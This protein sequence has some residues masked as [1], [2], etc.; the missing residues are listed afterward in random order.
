MCRC[1]EES[2]NLH[3]TAGSHDKPSD[4]KDFALI[5]DTLEEKDVFKE[6]G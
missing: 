1:F 6:K 3:Q 2:L 5:V 4:T